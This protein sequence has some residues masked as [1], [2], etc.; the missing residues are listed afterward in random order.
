[1]PDIQS[2]IEELVALGED[3]DEMNFWG[4]MFPNLSPNDQKLLV[5]NLTLELSE[6]RKRAGNTEADGRQDSDASL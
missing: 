4:S 3:R 6:L 5:D 2:I 1:M